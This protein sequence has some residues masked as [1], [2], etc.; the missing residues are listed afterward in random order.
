MGD[1]N[2]LNPD[3]DAAVD[4]TKPSRASGR[5][6]SGRLERILKIV[7]AATAVLSLGA[8]LYGLGHFLYGVRH[9]SR[10]VADLIVIAKNQQDRQQFRDAWAILAEASKIEQ[11]SIFVI[12][13]TMLHQAKE[14][15]GMAWLE[16]I[17]I[18]EG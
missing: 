5:K 6:E 4:R 16:N 1:G 3:G 18:G 17:R 13:T 9:D 7:G 8:A 10:A 15:L 12:G 11:T 2:G 14:D